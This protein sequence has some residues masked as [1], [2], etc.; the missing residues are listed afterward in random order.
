MLIF[1][2]DF[3]IEFYNTVNSK[4][5]I[6]GRLSGLRPRVV[7]T[8]QNGAPDLNIFIQNTYSENNLITSKR[9]NFKFLMCL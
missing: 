9:L 4:N 7:I 1:Q 5:S 8:T 3:K 6:G 2:Y